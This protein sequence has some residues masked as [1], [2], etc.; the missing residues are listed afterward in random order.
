[1]TAAD[2]SKQCILFVTHKW[3]AHIAGHYQR[4]RREA[5]AILDVLLVYQADSMDAA[6]SSGAAPDVVVTPQ[7]IEALFP[8]RYGRS[9]PDWWFNCAELVWMTACLDERL[10]AYERFWAIEYDVDFSG[11]WASFFSE[12]RDYEG[13]LLG[14]ALR[15]AAYS[16]DWPLL[17]GFQR[18]NDTAAEPVIGFF[19]FVRADRPLLEAY[20]QA[21]AGPGWEGHFEIVLPSVAAA[22]GFAIA[23]IGGTGPYCPAERRGQH[24]WTAERYGEGSATF[25]FRPARSFHYFWQSPRGFHNRNFLYHPVKTGLSR[26]EKL[27]SIRHR[28]WYHFKWLRDGLR[29]RRLRYRLPDQSPRD[30]HDS[31][32][33]QSVHRLPDPHLV[34]GHRQAR[35]PA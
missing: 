6:T 15:P 26:R 4:L 1:M 22:C 28:L 13:A 27:A 19:P 29:G 25:C 12:A 34:S 24:Y 7:A 16:P 21:V 23:E 32:R 14:V 3:D 31:D 10:S 30:V 11:D 20:R 35:R 2:Q 33:P 5:G 18:P 9:A 17:G 8:R